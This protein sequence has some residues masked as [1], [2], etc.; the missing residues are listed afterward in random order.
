MGWSVSRIHFPP[1][2][3]QGKIINLRLYENYLK[4]LNNLCVII[5][6]LH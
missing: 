4:Y 5:N 2:M 1:L 3:L 6:F